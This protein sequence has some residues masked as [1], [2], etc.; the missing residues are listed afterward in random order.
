M[1]QWLR[2]CLLI[3]GHGCVL[4]SGKIPLV[5]EQL[6]PCTATPEACALERMLR[7]Q[8][9]HHNEKPAHHNGSVAPILCNQKKL[10]CNND[11]SMCHTKDPVQ[12][13]KE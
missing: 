6:S 7:N 5:L 8:S 4:W 13:K 10:A 1:I 2:I 12:P 11:E 3:E 9:S